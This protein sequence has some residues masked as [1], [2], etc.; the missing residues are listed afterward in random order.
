MAVFEKFGLPVINLSLRSLFHLFV[1]GAL[2]YAVQ[3]KVHVSLSVGTLVAFCI[4][5]VNEGLEIIT[6]VENSFHTP[7]VFKRDRLLAGL[8]VFYTIVII[9]T[10]SALSA[11][12]GPASLVILTS[13]M[14]SKLIRLKTKQRN[15]IKPIADIMAFSLG[16]IAFMVLITVVK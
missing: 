3:T 1:S 4:A 5:V 6:Q 14:D 16:P 10:S 15:I 12:C 13:Y 8:T 2:F 7:Y 9:K 11:I